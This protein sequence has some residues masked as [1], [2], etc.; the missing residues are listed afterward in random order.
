[1]R[2]KK[3]SGKTGQY[4]VRQRETQVFSCVAQKSK[5]SNEYSGKKDDLLFAVGRFF[6]F[7]IAAAAT[8]YLIYLSYPKNNFS[9][10]AWVSFF[11]F[12]FM[13]RKTKGLFK[14][15]SFGWVTGFFTYIGI[16][17]WIYATC[18]AGGLSKDL[19]TMAVCA[20]AA[21]TALQFAVFG[22]LMFYARNL[23]FLYPLVAA[24]GWVTFELLHQVVAYGFLGFPWFMPGYSQWSTPAMIQLAS[25]GGVYI[26]S[27]V[28]VFISGCVA[29]LFDSENWGERFL[30]VF[31]GAAV[32]FAVFAFGAYRISSFNPEIKKTL[33]VS[34]LQ[35]NIDQYKKWNAEFVSEI[36][37][38][39]R[40]QLEEVKAFNP[41]II[42]W[43]E[44]ALPGSAQEEKYV[45]WLSSISKSYE[46]Y[47]L[48]GSTYYND[49]ANYVSA[50]L[51][52]DKGEIEGVYNKE[53]L[54]PF[55]E[56][57]PFENR[58][59]NIMDVEVLGELGSFTPG[60]PNQPL[61]EVAGVKIASNICYESIFPDLWTKAADGGAEIF[62]NVTNDGWYLDTSAPYQHFAVNVFRAVETGRPVVRSANTGISGWINPLGQV[63]ESSELNTRTVMNFEMP[64]YK[65]KDVTFYIK[66]GNLFAYLCVIVF[67][68][69]VST[70]FIISDD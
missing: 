13:L 66:W 64:V 1:M 44:T 21:V 43:P 52:N 39:L 62:F 25:F 42:V 5:D 18:R 47:Q 27:F 14:S 68:T 33:R 29:V 36:E 17:I 10:F 58:L 8:A 7:I 61:Y 32:L 4:V 22:G 40:H 56:Y 24:A 63:M 20:L 48:I 69:A 38:V 53:K 67:L 30:S 2:E 15:F 45:T 51:F 54:V 65:S 9:A 26:I 23:K 28:I 35:P 57:I 46:S 31:I 11:P 60:A 55:G 50:F 12:L 59:K 6:L 41:D 37:S 34:V 19:S 16:F 49:R 70:V 3:S